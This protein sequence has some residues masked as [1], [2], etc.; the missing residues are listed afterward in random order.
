MLALRGILAHYTRVDRH[1][2]SLRVS[3]LRD[4]GLFLLQFVLPSIEELLLRLLC[5]FVLA[6]PGE[7]SRELLILKLLPLFNREGFFIIE[8]T[9][10]TLREPLLRLLKVRHRRPIHGHCLIEEGAGDVLRLLF[11]QLIARLRIVSSL[12][13]SRSDA[14]LSVD[15]KRILHFFDFALL[16]VV[17]Q[18][19]DWWLLSSKRRLLLEYI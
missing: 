10:L 4:L 8:V 3:A 15:V 5:R 13:C 1:V 6:V 19:F 16:A 14:A 2:E 18:F 11:G 9:L 7:L 12:L 17:L